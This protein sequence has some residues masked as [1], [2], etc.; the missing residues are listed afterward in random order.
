MKDREE[1][2]ESHDQEKV[3]VFATDYAT[4]KTIEAA[5]VFYV[6]G[7]NVHHC[8]PQRMMRNETGGI[9]TMDWHRCDPSLVAFG[10]REA[11]AVFQ[12][13]HSGRI[14][15]FAEAKEAVKTH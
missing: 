4:G 12:T 15:S 13:Q 1:S 9:Y 5:Q 11:A 2:E 10:S 3:S 14:M 8:D 7:S 6:E